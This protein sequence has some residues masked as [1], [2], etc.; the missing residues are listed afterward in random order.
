MPHLDKSIKRQK[1][2]NVF[3]VNYKM[4]LI[5]KNTENILDLLLMTHLSI[6]LELI[7]TT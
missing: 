6:K 3:W 2:K 5:I 7:L 1:F 4:Y